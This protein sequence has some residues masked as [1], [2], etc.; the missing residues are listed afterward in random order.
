MKSQAVARIDAPMV[1]RDVEGL[2]YTLGT[3]PSSP[4]RRTRPNT[5]GHKKG[6]GGDV[7]RVAQR[8]IG[9]GSYTLTIVAS[10]GNQKGGL[11]F[12]GGFQ[13]MAKITRALI[14]FRTRR[15]W[16]ISRRSW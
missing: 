9:E 8:H 13:V 11:F 3:G 1:E 4:A 6:N 5:T 12:K 10:E 14:A 2:G 16:W 15:V 7:K